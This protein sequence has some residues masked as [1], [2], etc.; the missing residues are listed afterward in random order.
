MPRKRLAACR[1]LAS[2][3]RPPCT[4]PADANGPPDASKTPR[5]ATPNPSRAASELV[6]R[7]TLRGE[8]DCVLRALVVAF[9]DFHGADGVPLAG[10]LEGVGEQRRLVRG[11]PE[12]Q[13]A[14]G[15]VR[16]E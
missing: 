12:L 15:L 4:G 8:G 2:A 3:R 14:G 13:C 6:A 16:V 5:S 1:V 7:G 9:Q 10:R 11:R